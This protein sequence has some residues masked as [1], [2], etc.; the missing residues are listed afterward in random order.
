[1][2]FLAWHIHIPYT[3]LLWPF[4][5][6]PFC[7]AVRSQCLR[8]PGRRDCLDVIADSPAPKSSGPEK[9]KKKKKKKEQFM[10]I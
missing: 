10:L 6:I 7:H 9:K 5:A 1:M 8:K 3:L 2:K 4:P